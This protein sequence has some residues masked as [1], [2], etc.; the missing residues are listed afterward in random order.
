MK[1]T[2][3]SLFLILILSG[4]VFAQPVPVF[5]YTSPFW[6]T[7]LKLTT[8][9]SSR[10]L[11]GIDP[12]TDPLDPNLV[13]ITAFNP[14]AGSMFYWSSP[15]AMTLIT[16]TT[17]GRTLLTYADANELRPSLELGVI[18]VQDH[19]YHADPN[20]VADSTTAM[21]SALTAAGG[22]TLSIPNGIYKITSNLIYDTDVSGRINIQGGG[23]NSTIRI[24]GAATK[25]LVI[26]GSQGITHDFV[27]LEGFR[28]E[29]YTDSGLNA[30]IDMNGVAGLYLD[31]LNLDG[32]NLADVGLIMHGSGIMGCQQGE[33]SGCSI[34]Q[35]DIGILIENG[36]ANG[37]EIHGNTLAA[38][39][40]CDI[41]KD[42]NSSG[43]GPTYIH[44]NHIV[45]SGI[46]F[47]MGANASGVNQVYSNVF[48]GQ[49]DCTDLIKVLGGKI[50]A[51]DNLLLGSAI[52]TI[53]A[54][55][56]TGGS[57][58][59]IVGNDAVN[60]DTIINVTPFNYSDN[61]T[62][63]GDVSTN[64]TYY[65]AIGNRHF[66]A[67]VDS[68]IKN[69]FSADE[70]TPS[71]IATFYAYPTAGDWG[72]KLCGAGGDGNDIYIKLGLATIS[73]DRGTGITNFADDVNSVGDYKKNGTSII[74]DTAFASS[75]DGVTDRAP[76][77]NSLY[78]WGH[79]FD[80][81]DDGLPNKL[82]ST[83]K[84]IVR[85]NT[86]GVIDIDANTPIYTNS[87][88]AGGG[89]SG[90]GL[91]PSVNAATATVRGAVRPDANNL[92]V[93][94]NG[95][96]KVFALSASDGDPCQAVH[97]DNSGNTGFGTTGQEAKMDII[98]AT[99][100]DPLTIGSEVPGLILQ[101]R[102]SLTSPNYG[103][104]LEFRIYDGG[105]DY[106]TVGAIGALD[107][108]NH[109]GELVLFT[110]PGGATNPTGRR[111]S[112]SSLVE[113]VRIDKN[114]YV[115]FGTADPNGPGIDVVGTTRTDILVVEHTT[116]VG[117]NTN[118]S[119][120]RQH[121]PVRLVD[122]A[123]L[124]TVDP[125]YYIWSKTDAALKIT[126]IEVSCDINPTTEPTF[127]LNWKDT[128]IG[129]SNPTL[130][131]ALDTAAGVLSSGTESLAVA[132]GKCIYIKFDTQPDVL[133][134]YIVI[135]LYFDYD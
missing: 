2:I 114:G 75:F 31:H 116:S 130:I 34:F 107:A 9:A 8:A 53:N 88:W 68:M 56:I 119:G 24:Y 81:D 76:S 124:Y 85:T 22:K 106:W 98:G 66:G 67:G 73:N 97:V 50:T 125:N 118:I 84:G 7:M 21:Q 123:T 105:T 112:G 71:D 60:A 23:T 135:D 40:V 15:T 133:I 1:K 102:Q 55:N 39:A 11:L 90:T 99:Q 45:V 59:K 12:N 126:S 64:Q 91:A 58:H 65:Q 69:L 101:Q 63:V 89:L 61:T 35:N 37:I 27:Y 29:D 38:N 6:R 52:V 42:T 54:F 82:D 104:V 86:S 62:Y 108:A 111:T 134:K 128:M 17:F 122:P 14:I 33:I 92:S 43:D 19:P 100:G 4:I 113:R 95:K 70:T 46:G 109:S 5:P 129:N 94:A 30:L 47:E 78:D 121:I 44:D 79:K 74:S 3:I 26:E 87:T 36:G 13:L 10:T 32:R 117:D 48:E 93:D 28:I 49:S 25:G 41:F 110:Q 18:N 96:V 72:I 80:T 115:G 127:D 51:E 83:T 77:K 20:G 103:P 132:A 57:Y 131:H 16:T 120:L